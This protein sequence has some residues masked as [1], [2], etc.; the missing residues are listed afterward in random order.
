MRSEINRPRAYNSGRRISSVFTKRCKGYRFV[1]RKQETPKMTMPE[2]RGIEYINSMLL[3]ENAIADRNY[4]A[5]A[6]ALSCAAAAMEGHPM[7]P[8]VQFLAEKAREAAHLRDVRDYMSR[9]TIYVAD[10]Q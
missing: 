5:A 1:R 3:A 4:R 8:R 2:C 6:E 7:Q 10:E 9:S